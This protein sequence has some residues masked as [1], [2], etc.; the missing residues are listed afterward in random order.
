MI[1]NSNEHSQYNLKGTSRVLNLRGFV[2]SLCQT[3]LDSR[4][5]WESLRWE[6]F[7]GSPVITVAYWNKRHS[8]FAL[9]SPFSRFTKKATHCVEYF[10]EL[11]TLQK[12]FFCFLI[13]S[14]AKSAS[15]C[16][17]HP[18]CSWDRLTISHLIWIL[19]EKKLCCGWKYTHYNSLIF[20]T[21]KSVKESVCIL[22]SSIET[23]V[24][25]FKIFSVVRY[26]LKLFMSVQFC[27]Y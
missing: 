11:L 24:N 10:S 19:F 22:M 4:C 16:Q 1:F 17:K 5:G 12:W 20:Q 27:Y 14:S 2:K 26:C 3:L 15:F 25:L 8:R 13:V 7:V 18:S 6:S 23:T 21:S 9:F